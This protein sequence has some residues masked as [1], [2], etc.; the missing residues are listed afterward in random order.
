VSSTHTARIHFLFSLLVFTPSLAHAQA[1]REA[2]PKRYLL[3]PGDSIETIA[4]TF[5]VEPVDVCR[6]N[7]GLLNPGVG[8][9]IDLHTDADVPERR[10][11]WIAVAEGVTVAELAERYGVEPST[12]RWF[13]QLAAG[14]ELVPGTEAAVPVLVDSPRAGVDITGK[15]FR[16]RMVEP[17]LLPEGE[18]WVIKHRH[19]AWGTRQTVTRVM[20]LAQSYRAAHP[21]APPMVVGDISRR[22]GGRFRPHLSHR[23]GDDIDIGI[24]VKGSG[25]LDR[26]ERV[27]AETIDVPRT[28]TLIRESVATGHVKYI[29]LDYRLQ[30]PL[31][32]FARAQ[33][34]SDAELGELFEYPRGRGYRKGIVRHA[35]GHAN[36]LHLRYAHD[37]P[38]ASAELVAALGGDAPAFVD[39][40]VVDNR[41]RA[42]EI[43]EGVWPGDADEDAEG[44]V[45]G[46]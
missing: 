3:L 30:R 17:T 16:S 41:C 10:L 34:L 21:D 36:H 39:A 7:G 43:F 29:F 12:I 2:E 32:D 42:P 20:D 27:N 35:R 8:E 38:Q 18:D 40:V 9:V 28:W 6:W 37:E 14:E 24:P 13:N 45:F 26:F 22:F 19:H 46:N 31:Y 4:E 23:K 5:G 33:G 15:P 25:F 44:A 1:T 11:S